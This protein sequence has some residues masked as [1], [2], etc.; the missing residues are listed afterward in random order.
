MKGKFTPMNGLLLILGLACLIY[1]F[2]CGFSVRFGLSLLWIW[3]LLGLVLS[4]RACAGI[5]LGYSEPTWLKWT[6]GAGIVLAGGLFVAVEIPILSH[7]N[8]ECPPGMD[9]LVVLGAKVNGETPSPA[10]QYRIG[11]ALNY[12]EQNPET[13]VIASGGQGKDEG[14]SEAECMRRAFVAAGIAP[15]RI[16]IEDQ[17][18]NTAENLRFSLAMIPQESQKVGIVTNNFHV[19]RALQLAESLGGHAFYGQ[20]TDFGLWMLPHYLVREFAAILAERL[21]GNL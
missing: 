18:T 17:S 13:Q 20:A 4:V 8:D 16:L 19:Y 1:Y 10:L 6:L 14:I 15:E 3:L 5:F 21:R 11:L 9:Y 7:M 12:L 2:V